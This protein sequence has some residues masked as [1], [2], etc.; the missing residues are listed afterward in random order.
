VKVCHIAEVEP[1][2]EVDPTTGEETITGYTVLAAH[3]LEVP[4][5]AA[6]AH[7]GH[8]DVLVDDDTLNHGDDCTSMYDGVVI[9][10]EE[11]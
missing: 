4:E 8:H 1:I 10:V 6:D 7:Q 11:E 5:P 9:P 2:I 3:V